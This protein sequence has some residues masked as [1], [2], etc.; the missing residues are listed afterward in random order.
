[1][2]EQTTL[3]ISRLYPT[4]ILDIKKDFDFRRDIPE[5]YSL[6]DRPGHIYREH[7]KT[8]TDTIH[9]D[10][11]LSKY[12]PEMAPYDDILNPLVDFINE[13]TWRRAENPADYV[14]E[15]LRLLQLAH[16]IDPMIDNKKYSFGLLMHGGQASL[17]LNEFALLLPYAGNKDH[18]AVIL[19]NRCYEDP[20]KSMSRLASLVEYGH[21]KMF[22]QISSQ[23]RLVI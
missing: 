4:D 16:L 5:P 17:A 20:V 21:S 11:S 6:E 1:M 8:I 3:H 19:S 23:E 14:P 9:S 15:N 13:E 10:L 7:I 12:K 18:S 2:S 22:E